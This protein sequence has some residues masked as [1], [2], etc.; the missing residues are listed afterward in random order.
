MI[1]TLEL[2][3]RIWVMVLGRDDDGAGDCDGSEGLWL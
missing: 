1:L 3:L 2:G